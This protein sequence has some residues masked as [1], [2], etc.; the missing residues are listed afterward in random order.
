METNQY[1]IAGLKVQMTTYGERTR[2]Q[3]I[4][5]LMPFDGEPDIVVDYTREA[6]EKAMSEYPHLSFDDKEYLMTGTRFYYRFLPF[7]GF[8]LHSSCVVADD[9]KAYLFSAQ[10]GTGKSTHTALWLKYL[11]DKARI[12]NDDKP[13]VRLENGVF[14]AYGT[15]WSGKTDQNINERYPI[16]GI[17]FLERSTECFIR[18]MEAEDAIKNL[19]WQTV[20]P[21]TEAAVDMLFGLVE[22]VIG[23]V[24]IRQFGCDISEQAF[25]TSYEGLTGR[26][27]HK[28]D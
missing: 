12:L 8:M 18:P 24:P 23:A 26:T 17:A 1:I 5:Y 21:R 28:E 11:G 7:D 20:K 3:S 10:P 22:K 15:P 19:Y 4:P 9:G 14:Y 16:G 2:L 6:I 27:Y 25:R 13:A